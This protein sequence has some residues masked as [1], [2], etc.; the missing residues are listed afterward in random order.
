[1]LAVTFA[2]LSA[3]AAAISTSVQHQAAEAAPP[4]VTGA[5]NLLGHL[6]RRPIWLLGQ[7]LGTLALVFHALALHSGPIAL[8]QP[9]VISGIVLAVPVRAAIARTL[10]PR[11]DVVAVL[12]AAVGLATFLVVSDPSD[13][14]GTGLGALALSLVLGCLAVS[15]IAMVLAR[16]LVDPT[17]RAFL[18]GACSGVF[19][20][21][22]AVLLKMSL[23]LFS[24]DGL[25]RVFTSWPVYFLVLAGTGGILGNQLAYRSAR[26]ASS[27]PVLNVVD[28]LVALAFGYVVFHEVPR[29][30]PGV[31]VLE[32][33][34]LGAMLVGLWILVRNT[35]EPPSGA[36]PDADPTARGEVAARDR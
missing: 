34:A 17:L 28:C 18:L 25:A 26:L 24:A 35:V 27:M 9:L 7:L 4:S 32:V 11:R 21:L 5:W 13:G 19:F 15:S 12:I 36:E 30:T 6:V 20:A 14:R 3:S 8:V 29:H 16:R 33:L 23:D 31:A 22:V 10:P 1:M 2:L